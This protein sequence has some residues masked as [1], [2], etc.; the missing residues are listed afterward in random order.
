MRFVGRRGARVSDRMTPVAQ[1]VVHEGPLDPDGAE[2][3]MVERKVKKLPLVDRGGVLLGLIT[4]RDLV[5]RRRMP[6]ATRDARGRL[7]VGAAIGATGDYIERATELIRAG[8]DVLVIDTAL[9]EIRV[10][11]AKDPGNPVLGRLLAATHQ[12]K[13]DTLRRVLRLTRT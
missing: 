4:S 12:K 8:V 13:V 10:A 2:R 11:L 9:A 1:L 7:R 3:V 5:R 6:F